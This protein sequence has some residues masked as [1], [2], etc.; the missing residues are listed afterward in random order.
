MDD[1]CYIMCVVLCRTFRVAVFTTNGSHEEMR[2]T[3]T[4]LTTKHNLSYLRYSQS[5]LELCVNFEFSINSDIPQPIPLS[6]S[7][8]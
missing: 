1:P 7:V 5:K 8:T 3:S 2:I 6:R 4:L